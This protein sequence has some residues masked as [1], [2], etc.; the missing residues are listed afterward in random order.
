MPAEVFSPL[1]TD[2]K[3]V[4]TAQIPRGTLYGE[5]LKDHTVMEFAWVDAQVVLFMSI[6]YD[7]R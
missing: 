3:L 6:V 1:L 5:L 2:L 4:H 7:G